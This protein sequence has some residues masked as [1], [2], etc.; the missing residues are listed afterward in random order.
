MQP[1][2]MTIRA[3][4][5]EHHVLEWLPAGPAPDTTV[6]CCHGY[7]DIG[8]SWRPVAERLVEAG[9][10]VVAFDWRGHARTEWIGAGG[11]YYFTDYIAD[12]ADMIDAL[13]PGRLHLVGHSMGGGVAIHY[14]GAFPD[15]VERLVV[16]EGLGPPWAPKRL[17][18]RPPGRPESG[19][20]DPMEGPWATI[21][22]EK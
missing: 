20:W 11:Y 17:P 22:T 7:L 6:L 5:L 9:R 8:R 21:G 3:G 14:A 15:R 16:M 13:V 2:E 4:G 1:N 10:R 18:R 12:L 19:Q